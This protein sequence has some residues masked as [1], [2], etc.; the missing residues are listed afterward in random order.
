M[1]SHLGALIAV[2]SLG[3]IEGPDPNACNVDDDCSGARVCSGFGDCEMPE[4]V[5]DLTVRWTFNGVAPTAEAPGGCTQLDSLMAG[6]GYPGGGY[7]DFFDC[8]PGVA[9]LPRVP[10]FMTTVAVFGYRHD[11]PNGGARVIGSN[12]VERVDATDVTVDVTLP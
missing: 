1:R 5:F 6:V 7:G 3:C 12:E 2:L 10:R 9:E 8:A 11:Q 4:D